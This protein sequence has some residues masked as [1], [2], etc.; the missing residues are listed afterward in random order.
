MGGG[1]AKIMNRPSVIVCIAVLAAIFTLGFLRAASADVVNIDHFAVT[2][3]GAPLF[4]DSFGAGLTLAGGSPPGKVLPSGQNFSTG[5]PANYG[6]IGTLT[7]TGNKGILNSALGAHILQPPPFFGA[8]N[9]NDVDVLTGPPT[10]GGV[11]NPISL[12]PDKAF[13]TTALFDLTVPQTVG[14]L[15]H[16]E[17]SNRVASNMGKGDVLSV[18]LRNCLP[19]VGVCGS[20]TGPLLTMGDANFANNTTTIIG[21]APVDTSN[22]Q[23]RFELSHP[24]AGT[25]DVFGSFAYVNNGVEGPLTTLGDFTGLFDGPGDPGY[26]QAGFLQLAPTSVTEPSSLTLLASS[27]PSVLGLAWLRRRKMA[28]SGSKIETRT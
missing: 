9:L 5:T 27:I 1:E 8:I 24:T 6:V 15:Y 11:T 7:E 3:N 19:G 21:E 13:N 10:V 28:G 14:G 4:D 26:T 20:N 2:L 25:D 12:T 18:D 22:Q 16:V 17:L 23:I